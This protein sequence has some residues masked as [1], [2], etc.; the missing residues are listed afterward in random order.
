MKQLIFIIVILYLFNFK[1]NRNKYLKDI[2]FVTYEKYWNIIF[3]STINLSI[4]KIM[5]PKFKI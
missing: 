4:K 3:N 1:K 5:K 2:K